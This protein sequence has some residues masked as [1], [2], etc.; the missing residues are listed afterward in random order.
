MANN[1]VQDIMTKDVIT[2]SR[3]NTF[4]E[5]ASLMKK[6]D[7][8]FIPIISN[9][10]I[11][12]VIT[13]RDIVIRGLSN[14]ENANSKISKY[15]TENVIAIDPNATID[16]ASNLMACKQIKRLVVIDND[17]LVGILS[18]SDIANHNNKK[19]LEALT[20]INKK[21]K[22]NYLKDNPEID[23]FPL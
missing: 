8:G 18:L 5:V 2:V 10:K 21:H 9:N 23:D 3:E 20:G 17:K 15:M 11:I 16:E 14:K 4:H 1:K 19:A 22:K 6:Y 13:D 12:G 7:I